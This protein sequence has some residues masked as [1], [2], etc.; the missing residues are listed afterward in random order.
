MLAILVRARCALV[1][2]AVT[3]GA[4]LL[5]SGLAPVLGGAVAAVRSGRLAETTFDAAL[6]WGCAA[7]AAVITCWGWLVA[8]VVLL[9]LARGV[10]DD[11]R[12]VPAALRRALVV[13]CGAALATGL[14]APTWADAG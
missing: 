7:A 12:G 11:R 13:L 4:A 1:G 6:V 9:D 3:A 8:L 14:A 5:E 10:A 2:A